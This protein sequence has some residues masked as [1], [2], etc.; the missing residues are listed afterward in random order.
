[1]EGI[2][3]AL[4]NIARLVIQGCVGERG[5]WASDAQGRYHHQNWSRDFLLCIMLAILGDPVLNTEHNREV[6][7]RHLRAIAA[8]QEKSSG[9]IPVLTLD[10]AEA[11]LRSKRPESFMMRRYKEELPKHPEEPYYGL[12]F[13]TP[14]TTDPDLLFLLAAKPFEAELGLTETMNLTR[15]RVRSMLV[16]GLHPGAD[17]RDARTKEGWPKDKKVDWPWLDDK[18]VLSKQCMLY[19]IYVQDGESEKAEALRSAINARYYNGVYYDDY[20]GVDAEVP[21]PYFDVLGNAL[22]CLYGVADEK[23]CASVFARALA[24]WRAQPHG[25]IP[26]YDTLIPAMN[27][28]PVEEA[29]LARDKCEV[30]PWVNGFLLLAMLERGRE[31]EATELFSQWAH[32]VDADGFYEWYDVVDGKGHGGYHQGWIAALFLRVYNAIQKK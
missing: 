23:Q 13:L 25:M 16:D 8:A 6:I 21:R 29:I 9:H 5:I 31:K 27:G 12:H 26:S 18:P 3:V 15:A 2:I 22:A 24:E 4:A 11:F 19:R 7:R 32:R 28:N 14:G 10:D 17:H 30:Y 1:M 20:P